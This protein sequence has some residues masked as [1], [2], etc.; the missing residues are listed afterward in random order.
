MRKLHEN[1]FDIL[2]CYDIRTVAPP[3]EVRLRKMSKACVKYGQ[4]VQKSVFECSITEELL[5]EMR[6]KLLKIMDPNED[7]LRIYRMYGSRDSRVEVYGI[8]HWMD[9]GGPLTV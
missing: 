6:Q 1:R 3:G 5:E 2:V 8:D 7:S 4:R 9:F